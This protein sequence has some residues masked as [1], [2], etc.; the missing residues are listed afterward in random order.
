MI[1][2]KKKLI[3]ELQYF[4]DNFLG[5]HMIHPTAFSEKCSELS[6]ENASFRNLIKELLKRV[7]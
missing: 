7:F 5:K 2:S 3:D 6:I 4:S 1:Y